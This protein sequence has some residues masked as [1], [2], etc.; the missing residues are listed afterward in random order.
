MGIPFRIVAVVAAASTP[1]GMSP[2]GAVLAPVLTLVFPTVAHAG[3][4]RHA[5]PWAFCKVRLVGDSGFGHSVKA[6]AADELRGSARQQATCGWICAGKASAIHKLCLACPRVTTASGDL[7]KSI[8]AAQAGRCL[9]WMCPENTGSF[10]D[11]ASTLPKLSRAGL[12]VSKLKVTRGFEL[13]YPRGVF[14][15]YPQPPVFTPS[16]SLPGMKNQ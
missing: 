6:V 9:T 10:E 14:L 4:A 7:H 13:G 15:T 12:A 11:A 3:L 5:E 2:A 8:D 1:W 16:S